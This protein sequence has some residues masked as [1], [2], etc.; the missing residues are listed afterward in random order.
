MKAKDTKRKTR[1][2]AA[3]RIGALFLA[4][5][6]TFGTWI[7]A[8]AEEPAPVIE[9]HAAEDTPVNEENKEVT[10]EVQETPAQ[11]KADGL[12]ISEP[13]IKPAVGQSVG[14][15][16]NLLQKGATSVSG[17][18]LGKWG[19]DPY[20]ITLKITTSDGNTYT[21]TKEAPK[22]Y[23]SRWKIDLPTEYPELQVGDTVTVTITQGNK[24]YTSTAVVQKTNADEYED[25][26]TMPTGEIWIEQTSS[27][28]VNEDE[29]KEAR[30]MF[31]N[32]NTAIAADIKNVKFIIDGVEHAYYEVTYKDGSTSGKIEAKD[33]TVYQVKEYS[34]MPIVKD[35]KVTTDTIT[36]T[37]S[38]T[39]ANG[40]KITFLSSLDEREVDSYCKEGKCQTTK[41]TVDS[42]ATVTI[43]GDTFSIKISDDKLKL[44]QYFGIVVKEPHKFRSCDKFKPVLGIPD[45][46]S[47]R[48]PHKLTDADKKA[49]EQAIRDANTV[50]GVS[51]LPGNTK[52]PAYIDFDKE[53]NARIINPNNVEGTWDDSYENFTPTQNED[54]TYKV[55]GEAEVYKIQAKDL[56]KNLPPNS[57][58]IA[59]D[60]DNGQVTITPP[61]YIAE[62]GKVFDTDLASYTL[63]YTP[64]GGAEKT[65]TATRTVENDKTTW[66]VSDGA[67]IDAETGVITLNVDD[68]EVG[69]TLTAKAKDN[70]GLEGD[71]DKLDSD[72]VTKELETATV[73]YDANEG[74]GSMDAKTLNKGG[75][76]TVPTG[77]GSF[78]APENQKFAGKWVDGAN[79]E[80]TPGEDIDHIKG[81]MTLKPVWETIK[82]KVTYNPG[83]GSG[84]MAPEEIDKGSDYTLKSNTFDAPKHHKFS[85]WKVGDTPY[86]EN[87][88][89]KKVIENITAI[90]QW[91]R[92]QVT[93]TY[94]PGD[95]KGNLEGLT[96]NKV[97]VDMGLPYNLKQHTG[98]EPN[99]ENKV[100]SHWQI[101]DGTTEYKEG[102]EYTVE[103][104]IVVKAVWKDITVKLTFKPNGGKWTDGSTDNK[105]FEVKKGTEFDIIAAPTRDNYTFQYWKGSEF[106]PGQK[107]TATEDHEFEAQWKAD[108]P[109]PPGGNDGDNPGT[110][111]NQPGDPNNPNKPGDPNK[112][113][114]PNNP[115][116]PGEPNAPGQ[117]SDPKGP[118]G[119]NDPS[120]PW[121]KGNTDIDALL[122]RMKALRNDPAVRK[123]LEGQRVIPRAGVGASTTAVEPVLFPVDLLPAPKK[124]E[125]E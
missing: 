102:A 28:Q 21:T 63:S 92:K 40:T 24:E 86:D 82:V 125:E 115:N 38:N 54:G 71:T 22:R 66:S 117:S 67:K 64:A 105:V 70:G 103:G 7:P 122:R 34:A 69:G 94:D 47:V 50:N 33:L 85:G 121:G 35:I 11:D 104:N 65:V 53:G 16:I 26:L 2:G 123:I 96:D 19:S 8:F 46:V 109:T 13:D 118:K 77:S 119:P 18:V 61:A 110:N 52:E 14:P 3:R 89:V 59:V 93:V 78:E 32:V 113:N 75:K 83:D 45:K 20:P 30:S 68:I 107:Y 55:T 12:E 41:S 81:D 1:T 44:G 88:L 62:E 98:F 112:P 73:S 124:R 17:S 56:V 39:V 76:V 48:D 49:I 36:G 31:D 51:K 87:G 74:S 43:T 99:D 29:Q 60:T 91:Q 101:G 37:L 9:E 27:N 114:D 106:K 42:T 108:S 120:A 58:K 57:P 10:P 15:K 116:K 84:T 79:K 23:N 72:P 25:T 111:P 5:T 90:A 97:T 95:G 6:M 80:Y 4:L 100:F